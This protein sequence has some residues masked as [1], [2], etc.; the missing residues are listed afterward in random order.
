MPSAEWYYASG[1]NRY[2]PLSPAELKQLAQQGRLKPTDLVWRSGMHDWLPAAR[3]QGLFIS[4]AAAV[5]V[6]E[7]EQEPSPVPGSMTGEAEQDGLVPGTTTV[8]PLFPPAIDAVS[9]PPSHLFDL[10]LAALRAR[11]S[12]EFVDLSCRIFPAIG[13]YALYAAAG[14]VV[15]FSLAVGLL[16]H[17]GNA[18]LVGL[19]AALVLLAFQYTSRRIFEAMARLE[20]RSRERISSTAV[21]DCLALAGMIAGLLSLIT[22][23]VIG[24]ETQQWTLLLSAIASF[25]LAQFAAVVTLNP[26]AVGLK[27]VGHTTAGE[28]ALGLATFLVRLPGRMAPVAFGVMVSWATILLLASCATILAS[29]DQPSG[30]GD[31]LSGL[32]DD[33][34]LRTSLPELGMWN[35]SVSQM[36]GLG[37]AALVYR[38]LRLLFLAAAIPPLCYVAVLTGELLIDL[39]RALLRVGAESAGKGEEQTAG[40]EPSA[41]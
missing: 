31:L 12:V 3:V 15:V 37:A 16:I 7:S 10:L 23:T 27:V 38:A 28:E 2:G 21:L 32:L 40:G 25:V 17:N 26:A 36:L 11:F 20:Q 34:A 4:A 1:G 22:F 8:P 19:G 24:V 39:S 29:S 9:K 18:T 33:P 6:V 13:Y 35:N 30:G 41:R 14:I 5:P